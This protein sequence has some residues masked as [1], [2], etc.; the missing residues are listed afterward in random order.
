M[1]K[2]LATPSKMLLDLVDFN[3]CTTAMC[4]LSTVLKL[5]EVTIADAFY[6]ED[7]YQEELNKIESMDEEAITELRNMLYNELDEKG[8]NIDN[9]VE[10]IIYN[11]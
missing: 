9:T 4:N 3:C 10:P 7:K 6:F 8:Y 1:K 5:I 11:E 2:Y